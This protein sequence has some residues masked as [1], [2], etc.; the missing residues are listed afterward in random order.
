MKL[1]AWLLPF[2]SYAL[3]AQTPAS[4]RLDYRK[5]LPSN[6]VY[7]LLQDSAGFLWIATDNGLASYDGEEVVVYGANQGLTDPVVFGMHPDSQQRL[8]LQTYSGK[9]AVLHNDTIV[10]FAFNDRLHNIARFSLFHQID[11][12]DAGTL[13]FSAG[14]YIGSVKANGDTQI[15]SITSPELLCRFH[16]K[17]AFVAFKVRAS[18]I[19]SLR[20]DG[21]KYPLQL[22]DTLMRN[23]VVQT[24]SW[25]GLWWFSINN[26]I[27]E[28]N[29]TALRKAY[30]APAAII[31]MSVDRDDNLWIG[32]LGQGAERFTSTSFRDG[33]RPLT[34]VVS[35]TR[36]LK[37]TEGGYWF[38]TLEQGVIYLP[39]LDLVRIPLPEDSQVKFALRWRHGLL[40]GDQHGKLFHLDSLRRIGIDRQ[41]RYA[42]ISA[43]QDRK[44]R[45]WLSNTDNVEI[46]DQSL[47][48]LRTYPRVS[49]VA[50]SQ[51]N[52]GNVWATGGSNSR[53][54][55]RDNLVAHRY[56]LNGRSILATDTAI[57]VGNRVGLSIL[58]TT[59]SIRAEPPLLAPYKITRIAALAPGTILLATMGGGL[60][61]VAPPGKPYRITLP[62]GAKNIYSLAL[63]DSTIIVAT[64][65]GVFESS[66]RQLTGDTTAF[67]ALFGRPEITSKVNHLV[68][69][70]ETVYAIDDKVITVVPNVE[71][72]FL[73]ITPRFYLKK[74]EV[75][76][77]EVDIAPLELEP[78]E[79]QVRLT[80]G[81]LSFNNRNF[82][83][84]YRL[85]IDQ[86][87]QPAST[88][89][90]EFLTGGAGQYTLELEYSVDH[91]TWIPAFQGITITIPPVW[92]QRWYSIAAMVWL[93]GGFVAYI[94][95]AK[96]AELRAQR[97]LLEYENESKE[98]ML[99]FEL[100]TKER[101][102]SRVARDLHDGVNAHLQAARMALRTKPA[103]ADQVEGLLQT[104]LEEIKTIIYDLTPPGLERF[105]LMAGVANYVE[106]MNKTLPLKI[107]YFSYGTEITHPKIKLYTFRIVQ[108]LITN[109]LK[110]A[111][112]DHLSLHINSFENSLNLLFQDHGKGFQLQDVP[113]GHG[114]MSIETRVRVLGGTSTVSSDASGTVFSI[115]IPIPAS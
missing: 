93:A 47:R 113:S 17:K 84:R 65:Q 24:R 25:K 102:R 74:L 46:V 64:E 75:N 36:V 13:T 88:R 67:R 8:W 54:D 91:L 73:N 85:G 31:N 7:D 44:D 89:E 23:H 100:E 76:R 12:D 79:N 59:L 81:L 101:E 98:R 62:N 110:H 18:R 6:E 30:T 92:W 111:G 107:E 33:F 49:K 26:D 16:N 40:L 105:G 50:F 63:T 53:W 94:A 32:Y 29:G 71:K 103:N 11:Y 19:N 10:P 4:L 20:I 109:A 38:S 56:N 77:K 60:L 95:Y 35:V 72:Q 14:W 28:W 114:L 66:R 115:D 55:V 68:R 70:G 104:T 108:E 41:S 106:R 5:G 52:R 97:Q 51:D 37:D 90:V 48:T 82:F 99:S 39:H 87:W 80:Y 86:P 69:V 22:T 27:F 43:F 9:L 83:L 61:K 2:L 3:L 112:S 15:D 58:D 34:D 45:I 21:K 42:Y 57:Y 78:G 96:N 1:L